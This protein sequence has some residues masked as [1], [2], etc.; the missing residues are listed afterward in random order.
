MPPA[1]ATDESVKKAAERK[2]AKGVATDFLDVAFSGKLEQ[3]ESPIDSSL[4][5][6]SP[7]RERSGYVSG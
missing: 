1:F 3:A 4:K 5:N 6:R 7:K 2:W